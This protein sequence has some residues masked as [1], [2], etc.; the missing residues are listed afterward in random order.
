MST[1]KKTRIWCICDRCGCDEEMAIDAGG[2]N[3]TLPAG[4]QNIST[5]QWLTSRG[6]MESTHVCESCIHD[7]R[8]CWDHG[9]PDVWQREREKAASRSEREVQDPHPS[10]E[11]S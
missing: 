11:G 9:R 8:E 6:T 4:W 5:H 1:R 10:A 2:H 3:W 7:L